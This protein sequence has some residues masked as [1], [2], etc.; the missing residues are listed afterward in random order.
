VKVQGM[1]GG[2]D[3]KFEVMEKRGL[4]KG[5]GGGGGGPAPDFGGS[6][7]G[8][9]GESLRG[10]GLALQKKKRARQKPAIETKP[11]SWECSSGGRGTRRE[12]FGRFDKWSG[13]KD[14]PELNLEQKKT[15]TDSW[16]SSD[17]RR[18]LSLHSWVERARNESKCNL[19]A[20]KG[21]YIEKMADEMIFKSAVS[22]EIT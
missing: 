12:R 16:G 22:H 1:K 13:R 3:G 19:R 6:E 11:G 17:A 5:G 8:K 9:S 21:T 2:A 10:S 20:P 18:N 4:Q 14:F 15:V 7:E